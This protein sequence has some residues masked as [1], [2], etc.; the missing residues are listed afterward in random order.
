MS[1]TPHMLEADYSFS[2]FLLIKLS[3]ITTLVLA[4]ILGVL[5]LVTRI[6]TFFKRREA[7]RK[8][9]PDNPQHPILG[10]F[11]PQW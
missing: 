4:V 8:L 6:A 2:L 7:V 5:T 10:F 1:D 11:H 3:L 9:Q